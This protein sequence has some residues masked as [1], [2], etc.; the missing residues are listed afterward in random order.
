[1]AEQKNKIFNQQAL[2][3]INSPEQL[4][5]YMKVTNPGIWTILAAVILLLGGMFAWASV[6]KLET[7]AN[8]MAVIENGTATVMITEA[9]T[10]KITSEMS[11]RIDSQDYQISTVKYDDYGRAFA[12][13][14]VTLADG[15]YDAKI[16]VETISPLK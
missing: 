8:A 11:V 13:A 12:F 1:M 2:D 9:A 6:G 10:S 3:R 7:T 4:H 14:P 16:V 15:N 5:D